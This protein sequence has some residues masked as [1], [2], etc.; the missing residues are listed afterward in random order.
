[1]VTYGEQLLP[2]WVFAG[3]ASARLALLFG[4]YGAVGILYLLSVSEEEYQEERRLKA[5]SRKPKETVTAD[6][7]LQVR[8]DN[9]AGTI[10]KLRV[11]LERE[12]S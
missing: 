12:K 5:Q 11:G 2:G 10:K 8:K 3:R 6:M 4:L 7:R 1:M 9:L